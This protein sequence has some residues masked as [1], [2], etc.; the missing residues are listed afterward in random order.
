MKGELQPILCLNKA[1]LVDPADLQPLV[2]AYSPT[3]HPDDPHQRRTGDGIGRLRE[4]LAGQA[5][6]FSG[7][8]RRR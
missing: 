6:V 5:T 7:Q 2:G 8:S 4:L 3:R 1:D